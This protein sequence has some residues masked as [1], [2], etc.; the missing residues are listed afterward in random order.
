MS[1]VRIAEVILFVSLGLA[2]M[3]AGAREY[4]GNSHC[5]AEP[6]LAQKLRLQGPVMALGASVS[7][8]LLADEFPEIVAKQMCLEDGRDYFYR[9]AYFDRVYQRTFDFMEK[10]Y[11]RQRPRLVLALDYLYHRFKRVRF[12]AETRAAL[13][14]WL[15]RLVLDC[16]HEKIDC[17]EH[18]AY[19]FVAE[20]AYRPVVILGTVYYDNIID[21]SQ[22]RPR[23]RPARKGQPDY[24]NRDQLYQ[25]RRDIDA[26]NAYLRQK[27]S[28]YPNL[29]IF[30][31]YALYQ[32]L[33]TPPYLYDYRVDGVARSYHRDELLFDTFHPRTD[34]GALVF[35]NLIID[36]LNGLIARGEI[37]FE[38]PVPYVQI[39][40]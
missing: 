38:T 33:R 27:A 4:H 21:C 20:E 2:A 26:I 22:S 7:S 28:L 11:R 14:E 1:R 10:I 6:Q 31:V 24:L 40:R 9:F 16:G 29:F 39:G 36:Y 3:A 23:P 8:G 19:S 12:N 34:P 13:D 35:A 37:D 17:S 30:P 32:T 15:A 25:C 5:Q 18:G